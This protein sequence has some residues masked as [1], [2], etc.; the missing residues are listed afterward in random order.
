[1]VWA[2][3]E[4]EETGDR[5]LVLGPPLKLRTEDGKVEHLDAQRIIISARDIRRID[6]TYITDSN[7]RS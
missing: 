7:T 1:M 5:D 3:A 2:S 6:V 4:I